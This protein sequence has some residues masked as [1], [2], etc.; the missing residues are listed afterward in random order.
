L[1]APNDHRTEV[2]EIFPVVLRYFA[3]FF[4]LLFTH[5]AVIEP[6]ERHFRSAGILLFVSA[7]MAVAGA[8]IPRW[9]RGVFLA[10]CSVIAF[11]GLASFSYHE[12][13]TSKGY[14]LDQRSWTNQNLTNQKIFDLAAVDFLREAYAREGRNALF[15]LPSYQLALTLPSD[16]RV[17]AMD[18]NWADKS[19]I[20]ALRY[21]GRVPGH[22]FVLLPNTVIDAITGSVDMKKGP[23]LLS[24]FTD[25]AADSWKRKGFQNMSVFFQ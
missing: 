24:A 4:I 18:F 23:A 8:D 9:M 10:L 21:R 14:W 19:E 22:V 25:Y 3:A 17:L 11:F 12:L 13:T 5:G 2:Q 7:M 1:A 15:V 16:A 6:E 20:E